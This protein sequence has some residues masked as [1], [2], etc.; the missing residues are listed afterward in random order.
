MVEIFLGIDLDELHGLFDLEFL[1]VEKPTTDFAA[2][3]ILCFWDEL[4]SL[5]IIFK[6]E[7]ILF[8][9]LVKEVFSLE[10]SILF[11]AGLHFLA[12]MHRHE[13]ILFKV[14]RGRLLNCDSVDIMEW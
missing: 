14:V 11:G 4:M 12:P 1:K 10:F 6:G 8:I 7:R 2:S 3:F 9:K 5:D 13:L